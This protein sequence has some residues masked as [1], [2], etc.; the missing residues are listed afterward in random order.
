[1]LTFFFDKLKNITN[2]VSDK[3]IFNGIHKFKNL[4]DFK[5]QDFIEHFGKYMNFD[6]KKYVNW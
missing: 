1:M 6:R 3:N 5:K 2:M 4:K